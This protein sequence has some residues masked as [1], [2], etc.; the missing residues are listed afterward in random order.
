MSIL[1][2]RPATASA[3][4]GEPAGSPLAVVAALAGATSALIGLVV[5]ASLALTGWFLADA[6]AHGDTLD[7]VGVGA[8]VW[9]A[10]HGSRVVVSGVPVG[11]APLVV[12][13][14]AVLAAFRGGR[15]ASRSSADTGETFAMP[16]ATF[17]GAYVM[18]A[19]VTCVLASRPG[20]TP[21]L[22][23]AVLGAL[24]VGVVA[25]GT[26]LAVGSGRLA[27]GFARVPH[28]ASDIG[29]GAVT[30]VLAL[31]AAGALLA[32]GA[33]LLSFNE[34]ATVMSQ[35]HL[36][37]GE[38]LSYTVV[39]VLFAPNAA[40]FAVAYLL[41]PGF[42]FGVGTTVSPTAVSLGV[43]P[44]VPMLAALPAD[45]PTPAWTGALLAVPVLAAGLGAGFAVR[46]HAPVAH[47]L[48]A[49]RG[50]AAGVGAGVLVTVLV[51]VAGG[52]LGTGRMADVGAPLTEV[53]VFASGLMGVGGLVGALVGNWRQRRHG[54]G[55]DDGQHDGQHDDGQH[56]D[57]EEPTVEVL[58]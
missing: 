3:R 11:V 20:A 45:G 42:A 47:D 29:V 12:T 23:R 39:M 55:H 49:V 14:I 28:W 9:L 35:L 7:A 17:A 4:S 33:L 46:R 15:W 40:L 18:V 32:G 5:C 10:G 1:L 51:A 6:G 19:V 8:D 43:V 53:L 2:T 34:A 57:G 36:G 37:V 52:P 27:A 56:D 22:G 54:A 30:G 48:A 26:G 50:A 25:G 31:F 58:R 16:V 44:A 38:A 41:G 21:S 24:V 13:M